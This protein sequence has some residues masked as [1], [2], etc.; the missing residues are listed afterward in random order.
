MILITTGR[1]PC[2]KTRTFARKLANLIPH[3][4]Y[5]TRGKKSIYDLIEI[6]R[7]KGFTNIAF[8]MDFKG[9]PSKIDFISLGKKEWDWIEKSLKM[10]SIFISE[11]RL[12][13]DEIKVEGNNKKF[14]IDIFCIDED[15]EAD[16][17][18]KTGKD[19]FSFKKNEEEFLKTKMEIIKQRR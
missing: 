19:F 11:K 5:L 18:L 12:R 10:K 15:V 13:A 1:K 2:K 14:F 17:V 3:S 16:L 7:N 6:A 9:N 8:V 4:L